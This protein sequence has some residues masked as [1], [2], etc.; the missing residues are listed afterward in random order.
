MRAELTD[1]DEVVRLRKRTADAGDGEIV[2]TVH[3]VL[4]GNDFASVTLE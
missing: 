1:S 4:N 2:A 3:G